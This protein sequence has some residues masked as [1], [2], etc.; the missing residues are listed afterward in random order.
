MSR[1]H[2][3]TSH[4]RGFR[5]DD[6]GATAIEFAFVAPVLFF[7]LLSMIEIG[8][9]VMM[10]SGLDNAVYEA[11]RRIRTGR[12]D[13]AT[14]AT[15]FEDQ[16]CANLGGSLNSCRERVVTSVDKFTDFS[17]ANAATNTPPNGSFDKGG[18]GDIIIV[19]VDYR[20]PLMSPFVATGYSRPGPMEVTL[21]SRAA[22]K[23]EPF[24]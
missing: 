19:K 11:A 5:H 6:R 1:F 8:M 22:F 15:T 24:E 14:S 12:E 18:A 23:N 9:I 10:S 4:R 13:A 20:W 3:K 16:V 21:G 17:G 7:A 2:A